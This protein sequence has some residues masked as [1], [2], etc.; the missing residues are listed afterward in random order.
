MEKEKVIPL[1]RVAPSNQ[2][3]NKGDASLDRSHISCYKI[4]PRSD[5]DWNE[6]VFTLFA[7]FLVF[8]PFSRCNMSPE[9]TLCGRFPS[10]IFRFLVLLFVL[11]CLG[12]GPVFAAPF[13]VTSTADDGGPG[14]LRTG[15]DDNDV[16][17]ITFNVTGT[18]TLSSGLLTIS[19]NLTITGPAGGIS[20]SGAHASSVIA[21]VGGNVTLSSLTIKDGSAAPTGGGIWIGSGVPRSAIERIL[22]G[23]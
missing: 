18:I 21:V 17:S 4:R 12:V 8:V 11:L 14:T 20:I 10:S 15:V 5:S 9:P 1:W 23:K 7:L 2:N 16:D 3:S 19:R 6:Q 13:T 22:I